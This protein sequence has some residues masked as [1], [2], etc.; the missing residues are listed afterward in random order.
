MNYLWI[1]TETTGFEYDEGH[2]AIEVALVETTPDLSVVSSFHTMLKPGRVWGAEH[3]HGISRVSLDSA[4][5]QRDGWRAVKKYIKSLEG[6][7]IPAGQNLSFDLSFVPQEVKD[8]F[9][10]HKLDLVP[11][12]MAIQSKYYK[13]FGT[14]AFTK[15]DGKPSVS[16]EAMR[17]TFKIDSAGSHRALKDIRDTIY[18][19]GQLIECIHPALL[20]KKIKSA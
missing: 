17:K 20:N 7:C 8:L 5:T 11:I 18:I 12:S 9:S 10:Y 6:T 1:D 16:L 19:F 13:E 14:F 4:P 3:I 2:R 15:E